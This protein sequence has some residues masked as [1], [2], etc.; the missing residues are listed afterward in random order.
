VKRSEIRRYTPLRAKAKLTTRT[1]LTRRKAQSAKRSI[2]T[3]P[4]KLVVQLVFRRDGGCCVRCGRAVRPEGRGEEWSVQHRRARGAGGDA[5][6]ETNLPANLVILCGSAT[7]AGGC[8]QHVESH[9]AE[10]RLAGLSMRWKQDPQKVPVST[11]WGAVFLDDKGRWRKAEQ[12]PECRCDPVLC[13]TDASGQHCADQS[14][15]TCLHGCPLDY[16]T[17]CNDIPD[18]AEVSS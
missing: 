10:A 14:C 16:C 2:K 4:S 3:G 8:H 18:A 1:N 13:E 12:C 5:R 15:G 11:W 9:R 17:V 7:S 6:P